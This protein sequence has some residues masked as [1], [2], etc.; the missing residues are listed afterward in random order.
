MATFVYLTLVKLLCDQ[1]CC[2]D[3]S[4]LIAHAVVEIVY[5]FSCFFRIRHIRTDPVVAFALGIE[6]I[7]ALQLNTG[8][9]LSALAAD[10]YLK[11]QIVGLVSGRFM[12]EF[13]SKSCHAEMEILSDMHRYN[14]IRFLRADFPLLRA[15]KYFLTN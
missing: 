8:F 6:I 9:L 3:N 5:T 14:T 7:N 15:A 13:K 12:I 10:S 1:P 2:I 4:S 11:I